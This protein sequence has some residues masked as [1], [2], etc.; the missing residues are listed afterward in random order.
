MEQCGKRVVPFDLR[1]VH[2]TNGIRN[3]FLV[4]YERFVHLLGI[5]A[6]EL[7]V[8]NSMDRLSTHIEV[9]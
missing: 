6:D 1:T 7:T 4:F 8:R 9:L 2:E 5:L 3:A